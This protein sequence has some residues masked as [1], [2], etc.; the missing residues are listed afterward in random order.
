MHQSRCEA[1]IKCW[2]ITGST[3]FEIYDVEERHNHK[4]YSKENMHLSGTKKLDYMQQNL[5]FKMSSRNVGAIVAHQL[6]VGLHGWCN[7]HVGNVNDFNNFACDLNCH[8]CDTDTKY[9]VDNMKE[10][11]KH[12][13]NFSF[14]YKIDEKKLDV[15]FWAGETSKL[16]CREFGDVVSFDATFRTN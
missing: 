4:L 14:E 1:G 3:Q 16:H 12:V 9:L 11:V 13:N 5:I 2:V 10:N 7:Y 15:I 6:F 8:V